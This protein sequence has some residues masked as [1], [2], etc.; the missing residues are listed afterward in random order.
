MDRESLLAKQAAI[1]KRRAEL[2][3]KR[4]NKTE[5]KE[6]DV[7]ARAREMFS[8]PKTT[9]SPDPQEETPKAQAVE[10]TNADLKVVAINEYMKKLPTPKPQKK[11]VEIQCNLDLA[12]GSMNIE[13]ETT[14]QETA[15]ETLRNAP[16]LE[17]E[18]F[19]MMAVSAASLVQ[20]ET[21]VFSKEEQN[22]LFES[23]K[24][25]KFIRYASKCVE[26]I[27]YKKVDILNMIGEDDLVTPATKAQFSF[28]NQLDNIDRDI[29]KT[30]I[31]QTLKCPPKMNGCMVADLQW[32]PCL[33]DLV[34]VN[35][36]RRSKE[37][38][39]FTQY[40]GKLLIWS[41]SN[42]HR[43]EFI[44]QAKTRVTRAQFDP[45]NPALVY[46]GMS[47][48]SIVMWD[49][50]ESSQP[51]VIV[52]PSNDSHFTPVYGLEVVGT[53][54]SY[55]IISMSSEGKVCVWEPTNLSCPIHH[56]TLVAPKTEAATG[57]ASIDSSAPMSPLAMCA[58]PGHFSKI[59]VGGID[60]GLFHIN[61]N[62]QATGSF[63]LQNF[64]DQLYQPLH[65]E[66]YSTTAETHSEMHAGPIC[67]LSYLT[68]YSGKS[69]LTQGMLLSCSFDWSIKLWYPQL[70]TRCLGTFV[71][72]DNV[73]SD[74]QW[75]SMHPAKFVSCGADGRLL[76]WNLL[77]SS[78]LPVFE[79]RFTGVALTRAR[80]NV[81]G[82][83]LAAG[84]SEGTVHI[85][86]QRRFANQYEEDAEKHL[87]EKLNGI[88]IGQ[89]LGR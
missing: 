81:D 84:D 49:V 48:G 58:P 4:Q 51:S 74:V 33:P 75:N 15:E 7:L 44:M 21:K 3:A 71:G 35:Y 50:R 19:N 16:R 42:S 22:K 79:H 18:A 54:N 31:I 39:M 45:Y 10:K 67:G 27:L 34:L 73:V 60:K 76:I 80:W 12:Q 56:L 57:R 14:G 25:D 6:E 43:P 28:D 37:E 13:E 46:G 88:A 63:I 59:F 70:G 62:A 1:E 20:K 40:P 52:H 38:D 11:D 8:T 68:N 89:A 69:S 2:A 55:N 77:R 9:D 86:Q 30:K 26:N 47:N 87:K 64:N 72:H 29:E 78:A 65:R 61:L 66:S 36:S 83:H 82:R 32:N 53:R 24:F 85:L 5:N 23:E 17:V 41:A